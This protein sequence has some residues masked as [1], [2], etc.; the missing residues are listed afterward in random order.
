MRQITTSDDRTP[1]TGP[2][3][4][5]RRPAAALRILPRLACA[6][7][8]IAGLS[9]LARET[10]PQGARSERDAP[11]AVSEAPAPFVPSV[12]LAVR[13]AMPSAVAAPRFRLD[14]SGA[15]EPAR[16]EAVRLDSASGRREETLSLGAFPNIE[17]PY[18]RVT[19]GE[20]GPGDPA[21]RLFITL[22][23]R[24]ADGPGLS[25]IRTG[26]R[27]RIETKFGAVETLEA[28]VSGP[29]DRICTGFAGSAGAALRFDGWL[30]APLGQAPEP[31]AVAC[32]VDALMA[33]APDTPGFSGRRDPACRPPPDTR[34]GSL[35]TG[36]ARKN[37]ARMR[38]NTQA[39]P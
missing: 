15:G 32:A 1:E 5:R 3:D 21:G 23:R 14:D 24:A 35:A 30:C 17:A 2:A 26:E 18:L 11:A 29:L 22:A 16:T 34:T 9:L 7:A 28:T 19:V 27:G 12:S 33:T 10:R 6:A 31:R 25:V 4:P 20:A 38:R 37:E 36:S 39:Q 13:P 8:I